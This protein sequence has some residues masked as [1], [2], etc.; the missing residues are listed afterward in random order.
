MTEKTY[1]FTITLQGTGQTIEDAWLNALVEFHNDPG[2]VPDDVSLRWIHEEEDSEEESEEE[3][4]EGTR[5]RLDD[6]VDIKTDTRDSRKKIRFTTATFVRINDGDGKVYD[7]QYEKGESEFIDIL[8]DI[9][10]RID[11]YVYCQ[12][13]D[14]S[15]GWIPENTYKVVE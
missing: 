7:D 15:V 1:T 6:L 11:G 2:G 12:F 4:F 10:E 3:L 8:E 5:D 14:G 9:D 13:D